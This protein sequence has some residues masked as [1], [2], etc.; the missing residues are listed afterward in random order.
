MLVKHQNMYRLQAAFP[1]CQKYWG[2]IQL[3]IC[4]KVASNLVFVTGLPGESVFFSTI[5][6]WL[7]W[8]SLNM[9]DSKQNS[10]F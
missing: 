7:F 10:V 5:G 1:Q 3:E 6:N 9:A 4:E 8:F 2:S